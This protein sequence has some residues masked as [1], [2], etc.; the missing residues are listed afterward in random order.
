VAR[1]VSIVT[2]AW[3]AVTGLAGATAAVAPCGRP[4]TAIVAAPTPAERA[5]STVKVVLSP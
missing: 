4:V 2:T 3:S 1:A 5:R